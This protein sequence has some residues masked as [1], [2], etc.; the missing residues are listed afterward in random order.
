MKN[1]KKKQS[2]VISEM[3]RLRAEN[4]ALRLMVEELREELEA[5]NE[6]R[7][8]KDSRFLYDVPD[9]RSK[10]ELYEFLKDGFHG[11]TK[12][13]RRKVF[14]LYQ[15]N[16]LLN[17]TQLYEHLDEIEAEIQAK[18]DPIFLAQRELQMKRGLD[19]ENKKD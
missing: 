18:E 5:L 19:K 8:K 3:E 15:L 13:D 1:R 7:F 9:L 11:S 17:P 4:E 2:N 6:D 14:T 16:S 10:K 12:I